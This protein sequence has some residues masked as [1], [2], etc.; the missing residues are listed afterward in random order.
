MTTC[1]KQLS[2]A[3]DQLFAAYFACQI[4]SFVVYVLGILIGFNANFLMLLSCGVNSAQF[5][6]L[7]NWILES[8][9]ELTVGN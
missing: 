8:L 7:E 2:I 4:N 1:S 3:L 9:Q 5:S 6:S